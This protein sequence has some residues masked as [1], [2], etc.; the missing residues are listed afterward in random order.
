MKVSGSEERELE[1]EGKINVLKHALTETNRVQ[2]CT[3]HKAEHITRPNNNNRKE[4]D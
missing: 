1:G 4:E 3:Q 2:A